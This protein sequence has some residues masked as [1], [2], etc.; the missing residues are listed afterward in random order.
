MKH[1][2]LFA[3]VIALVFGVALDWPIALRLVTILLATA[4]LVNVSITFYNRKKS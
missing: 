2:S 1:I 3:L 4:V